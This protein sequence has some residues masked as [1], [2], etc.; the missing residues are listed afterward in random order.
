MV[1]LIQGERVGKDGQLRV[2][3]LV[4]IFDKAKEKILLT[5][6]RDNGRWCLPGG[7]IEP[8]ESAAEGAIRETLEEVGLDV[9]VK[10][11]VGIYSSPDHLLVYQSGHKFQYVSMLFEVE[12]TGGKLSHSDEVSENKFFSEAEISTINVMEHQVQRIYDAFAQQE[13]AFIR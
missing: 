9:R 11:L 13:A 7:G 2:S 1:K 12:V 6:R 8:G 10:R 5:R 4:A 3:S